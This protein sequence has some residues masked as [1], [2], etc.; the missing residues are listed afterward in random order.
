MSNNNI[1]WIIIS[2]SNQSSNFNYFID[3]KHNYSKF[4]NLRINNSTGV[5]IMYSIDGS[6][7]SGFTISTF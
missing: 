4:K 6:I 7:P 1:D 5:K 2:A 3:V